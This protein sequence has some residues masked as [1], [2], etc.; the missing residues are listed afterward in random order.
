MPENPGK[1]VKFWHELK[2]RKVIRAVATYAANECIMEPLAR[3]EQPET[4]NQQQP[5]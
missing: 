2:G 4:S 1:F 3:N 5:T